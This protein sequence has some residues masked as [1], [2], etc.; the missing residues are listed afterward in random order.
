MEKLRGMFAF[1]IWDERRQVLFAARDRLGIKPFYYY[2]DTQRFAFASEIKSLL[3]VPEIPREVETKALGEFLR[4]RYVIAPNTMLRGIRKL[5]PGH[6]ILV[7][8]SGVQIRK[9]WD[10]PL[11]EPRQISE[12]QAIEETGALLE[13]CVRMHLMADVPLGAFLSGGLDS[14]CVVA[15]MAKLGVADSRHSPSATMGRRAS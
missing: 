5:E 10:V 9:Y 11:V 15:L 4:R 12:A 7:N 1:A 3:E 14:S 6:S 13:E 2:Q 8:S